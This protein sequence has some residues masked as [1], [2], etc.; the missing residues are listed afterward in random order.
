MK[1]PIS[2]CF[3][4]ALQSVR[5]LNRYDVENIDADLFNQCISTVFSEP[6][7]DDVYSDLQIYNFCSDFS[8]FVSAFAELFRRKGFYGPENANVQKN[9]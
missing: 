6:Q 9:G 7:L 3:L 2:A 1:I 4:D 8:N 5:V